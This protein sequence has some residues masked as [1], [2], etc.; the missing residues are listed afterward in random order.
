MSR[1]VEVILTTRFMGG[2]REFCRTWPNQHEVTV[3][4]SHFI[5]ENS[6]DEI[7]RAIA[8]WYKTLR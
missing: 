2:R 4:G 1:D 7:G 3:K 6:P 5:Q 8:D